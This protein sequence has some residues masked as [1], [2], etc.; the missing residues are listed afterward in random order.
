MEPIE[1]NEKKKKTIISQSPDVLSSVSWKSDSVGPS[2]HVQ[3][4]KG[5]AL[6]PSAESS[7]QDESM[8]ASPLM[9]VDAR[10]SSLKTLHLN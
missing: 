3:S 6:L 5:Q 8:T 10:A 4:F 2:H 1:A 9:S 7:P